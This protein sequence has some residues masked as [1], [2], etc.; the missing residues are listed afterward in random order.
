MRHHTWHDM[1][2]K[3]RRLRRMQQPSKP[4]CPYIFDT[5]SRPK[6]IPINCCAL[7]QFL[8]ACGGVAHI[9]RQ[10]RPLSCPS[11]TDST[12]MTTSI[13]ARCGESWE[14]L[15]HTLRHAEITPLIRSRASAA[16]RK[17]W[18]RPK[19]DAYVCLLCINSFLHAHHHSPKITQ[20]TVALR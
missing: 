18:M 3:A 1:G 9:R 10:I 7:S 8:L 19:R 12:T 20:G 16:V 4:G 14:R 5:G 6:G 11:P 17:T 15:E 2:G 13:G